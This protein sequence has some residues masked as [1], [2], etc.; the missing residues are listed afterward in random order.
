MVYKNRAIYGFL[1]P[2]WILITYI[3]CPPV[4]IVWQHT[5]TAVQQQPHLYNQHT[6]VSKCKATLTVTLRRGC[7]VIRTHHVP[8]NPYIPLYLHPKLGPDYYGVPPKQE[9]T[10]FLVCEQNQRRGAFAFLHFF[11]CCMNFS[12]GIVKLA[13]RIK[14]MDISMPV[15]NPTQT[16][17]VSYFIAAAYKYVVLSGFCMTILM[18]V[19]SAQTTVSQ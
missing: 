11:L 16:K 19:R 4:N 6:A 7:L 5:R 14:C 1:G 15:V 12:A 2:S 13:I 3:I 10:W 18:A 9:C 17:S 8:Q